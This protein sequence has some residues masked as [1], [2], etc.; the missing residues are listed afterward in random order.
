[1]AR[2]PQVTRTIQTTRVNVMCLDIKAGQPF[3]K[4][5]VL[6]RVYKDD[7]HILK[8]VRKIIDNE[9]AKAVHIVSA[10]VE[11]TL[12]GMTEQRFIELAEVLPPRKV[13]GTD[14]DNAEP[15]DTNDSEN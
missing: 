3:Y 2:V 7:N 9:E 6:P 12:Y 10:T 4:E 14:T 8:Q 11:E 13:Y 5:V 15:T 1:M